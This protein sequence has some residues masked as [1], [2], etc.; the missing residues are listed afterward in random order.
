MTI[1]R[2]VAAIGIGIAL[3]VSHAAPASAHTVEF[4]HSGGGSGASTGHQTVVVRDTQC[5]GHGVYMEYDVSTIGGL[6]RFTTW[7]PD[8]C[9]GAGGQSNTYPQT[10]TRARL[11]VASE[12]C[13]LWRYTH[14]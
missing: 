14:W 12:G 7:D 11:C 1:R 5:D 9:G 3:L 10:I 6:V 2:L 13:T 4:S 8:E